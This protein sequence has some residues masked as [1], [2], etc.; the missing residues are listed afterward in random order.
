ML[1]TAYAWGCGFPRLPVGSF[2]PVPPGPS[3]GGLSI[4]SLD[5]AFEALLF[6]IIGVLS[7]G[8]DSVALEHNVSY[9]VAIK[10]TVN[11][12]L[13]AVVKDLTAGVKL[14][15]KAMLRLSQFQHF[16]VLL[17]VC[18]FPGY[19]DS[20][21]PFLGKVKGFFK[22]FSRNFYSKDLNMENVRY[23]QDRENLELF[24]EKRIVEGQ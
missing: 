11:S 15:V 8:G 10:D 14:L 20:I 2:G 19:T 7:P 13:Q 24:R 18:P 17:F 5:C 21:L 22:N 6:L 12:H 1:R 23:L 9:A 3:S 16:V 4:Q